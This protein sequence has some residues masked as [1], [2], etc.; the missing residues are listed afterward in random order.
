MIGG[1][2]VVET[3]EDVAVAAGMAWMLRTT[4]ETGSVATEEIGGLTLM[5]A[6][7]GYSRTVP[8]CWSWL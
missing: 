5:V 1:V 4:M 6:P 2:R 7:F 8:E 3:V